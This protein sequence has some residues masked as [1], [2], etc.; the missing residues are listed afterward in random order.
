MFRL[1][2]LQ[3]LLPALLA[4]LATPSA[5]A[6]TPQTFSCATGAVDPSPALSANNR[7]LPRILQWG[8]RADTDPLP[9]PGRELRDATVTGGD[10]ARGW[11]RLDLRFDTAIPDGCRLPLTLSDAS[12]TGNPNDR[13]VVERL[14][15]VLDGLSISASGGQDMMDHLRGALAFAGTGTDSASFRIPIRAS[16]GERTTRHALKLVLRSN[17]P[18]AFPFTVNVAPLPPFALVAPETTLRAGTPVLLRAQ[19]PAALLPGT[20]AMPVTFRLSSAA[21]G[22]WQ[23][24]PAATPTETRSVWDT[25][26]TPLRAEAAFV[27]ASAPQATPGSV[28]VV[29]AGRTQTLPVSIPATAVAA[30]GCEPAFAVAAAPGGL[31]LTLSNRA[32]GTCPAHVATARPPALAV[33]QPSPS[34]APLRATPTTVSRL[35]SPVTGLSGVPAA[36]PALSTARDDAGVLFAIPR[37]AFGQL[38]AGTRFEWDIEAEGDTRS[39]HRVGITLTAADVATVVGKAAP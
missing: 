5:T 16:E 28:A 17:T 26:F 39:K 22:R 18:E 30:A 19:H 21:L 37:A 12:D 8:V 15:R 7:P 11:L 29:W 4:A 38:K 9:P 27:P 6:Q 13:V 10:A 31:R 25:R 2:P 33:L 24:A 35:G 1:H 14:A 34:R 32:T 3:R 36:L 23:A 20:A